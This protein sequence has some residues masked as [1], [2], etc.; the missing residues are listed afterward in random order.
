MLSDGVICFDGT[1]EELLA[2]TDPIVQ[3]FITTFG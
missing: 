1:P 2:S 3:R